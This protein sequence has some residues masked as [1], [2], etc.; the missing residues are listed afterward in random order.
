MKTTILLVLVLALG[1]IVPVA[2]AD[3]TFGEPVNLGPI[4]NS[5]V[6]EAHPSISASGLLLYFDFERPG[7][8]V[9]YDLYVAKRHRRYLV[10]SRRPGLSP[11]VVGGNLQRCN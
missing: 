6:F 3:V 9:D 8:F 5:S 2:N 1:L 7:G 10:Y 11:T 4:I